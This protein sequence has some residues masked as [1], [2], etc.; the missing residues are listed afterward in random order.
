VEAVDRDTLA[1]Q[2]VGE[3]ILKIANVSS[4]LIDVMTDQE[5]GSGTYPLFTHAAP[6]ILFKIG[7]QY[8]KEALLRPELQDYA[9]WFRLRWNNLFLW[10]HDAVSLRHRRITQL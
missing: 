10:G 4:V 3:K 2:T 6:L 1:F 8:L 7:S 9:H 5:S